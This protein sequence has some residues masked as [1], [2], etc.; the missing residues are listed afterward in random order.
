[1]PVSILSESKKLASQAAASLVQSVL[2]ERDKVVVRT[3]GN[4]REKTHGLVEE[5]AQSAAAG[6]GTISEALHHRKEKKSGALIS[7]KSSTQPS[8]V[9]NT[10][11]GPTQLGE[12]T[13]KAHAIGHGVSGSMSTSRPAKDTE[14]LA[15][16]FIKRHPLTVPGSSEGRQRLALPVLVPQRR[17]EKRARGFIRAYA[18]MLVN[19]GID[20][21]IF[22]DFID[23]FNKSLEPSPWISAVNLAGFA[24]EALPDPASL[25]FGFAVEIATEAVMEGQSLFCSNRFLDCINAE[26]FIPRGL[27][28]LVVTWQPDKDRGQLA[29]NISEEIDVSATKLDLLQGLSDVAAGKMKSSEGLQEIKTQMGGLMKPTRGDFSWPEPAPLIFP[30]F[31]RNTEKADVGVKDKNAWDRM[32][33]WINDHS[34]KRAQ[35]SWINENKDRPAISLMPEHKFK[36]RYA[37]PNHQASSGDLV[38]LVT[39]G[40]WRL[41]SDEKAESS[42]QLKKAAN[43]VCIKEKEDKKRKKKD[44]KKN[45]KEDQERNILEAEQEKKVDGET[46]ATADYRQRN[47]ETIDM[48]MGSHLEEEG[49][50]NETEKVD[51]AKMKDKHMN[52]EVGDGQASGGGAKR[53]VRK[54][55]KQAGSSSK[56]RDVFKGLFQ[57][58]SATPQHKLSHHANLRERTYSTWPYLKCHPRRDRLKTCSVSLGREF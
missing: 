21:D 24:G 47:L 17:P 52:N 34:D 6:I 37:D 57:K 8:S 9:N 54:A 35:A 32:E 40:R 22:L 1:M 41:A 44:Q 3:G 29:T 50:A 19:V 30:N 12:G 23:T 10:E 2:K 43:E 11:S 38:S 48:S 39:A 26:F 56:S 53:R 14:G 7:V 55:K 36:S 4:S 28:C 33:N 5:I 46:R 15:F 42:K 51:E 25:L 16:A 18:P 45:T 27:I 31:K 58:A 49:G 20:Q 13:R